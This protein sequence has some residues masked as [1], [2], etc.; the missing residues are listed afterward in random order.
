VVTY[1]H[2]KR[3]DCTSI[4]VH[5]HVTQVLDDGQGSGGSSSGDEEDS[6]DDS[7][8]EAPSRAERP[9]H[10]KEQKKEQKKG[11]LGVAKGGVSKPTS[12]Q[13]M[14]RGARLH[15]FSGRSLFCII[16]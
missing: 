4:H 8:D 6:G 13:G 7:M 5:A 3:K 1:R 12:Q 16:T 11:G 9:A 10:K 2:R 14:T 15:V